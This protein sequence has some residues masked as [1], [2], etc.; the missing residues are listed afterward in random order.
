MTTILDEI[1]SRFLNN[2]VRV[3]NLVDVYSS[4]SGKGRGRRPVQDTDILR[5]A[6]VLLHATL[7]DLLRSL[8]EWRLP[9]AKPEALAEI[10]ICGTKR[11]A[12]IGLQELAG[13]RGE[14]INEIIVRSVREHLEKT[15]V[16]GWIAA[17]QR[18][19]QDVFLQF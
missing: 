6:V 18:L 5:A 1:R 14:T 16:S 9:T 19:G 4:K 12:R 13:F 7:E 3:T 8:A 2:L 17:V 10:P 15:A 11:G